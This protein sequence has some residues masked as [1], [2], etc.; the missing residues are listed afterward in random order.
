MDQ[1]NIVNVGGLLV[2]IVAAFGA[3][4][5]AKVS[6]KATNTNAALSARVAAEDGAYE[7]A[8]EFDM[9]IID[10]QEIELKELRA[11]N[12]KQKVKIKQIEE[13]NQRLKLE[14]KQM[15]AEMRVVRHRLDALEE[16]ATTNG[17]FDERQ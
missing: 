12:E 6:A 8:R 4:A 17:E 2:A 11:E 3:W 7:R 13:E 5:A 9:S 15:R 16:N 1:L 10:R 14:N